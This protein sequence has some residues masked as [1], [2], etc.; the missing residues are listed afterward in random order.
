MYNLR[1][2]KFEVVDANGAAITSGLTATIQKSASSITVYDSARRASKANP[3]TPDGRGCFAFWSSYASVDIVLADAT[4]GA[5]TF[6]D[7]TP[8]DHRITLAK[9]SL[10]VENRMDA[11]EALASGK[12]IV[13]NASGVA[14]DVALSGDATISN[15]G[16]LTIAEGAVEDS[17]IEALADGEI[18]IGVDGTAANNAKVTV[19][20][21]ASLANDG[22]LTATH[23]TVWPM[24]V[25][26]TL[27]ID[28]DGAETNGGGV[29]G[30]S[31]V[32]LTEQA[33]ALCVVEDYD[34]G[35]S[36]F[37]QL[38]TSSSGAGFTADYQLFPDTEVE[39]DAAYFGGAV[40]FC[41][42]ALNISATVATYGADSITWEYWDGA[43]WS[44]LTIVQDQTDADDAD[45]D[46]P[47]QQDGAIH[48]IPP[49]DWAAVEVNSQSAYWIRARCNATVNITQIPL[50]DSKEHEIVTPTDGFICPHDGTISAIRLH[51]YAATLHTAA[52]IKF[53]LVNFTTGAHSG[54]LTFAQDIATDYWSSLSLAV[55]A[56]DVLGVLITAEDGTNEAV[57]VQLELDVTLS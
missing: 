31:G 34:G 5:Y 44:A 50:T 51:D 36:D 14:A 9:Q 23:R 57:N 48:F 46:R 41:E 27:G 29:H 42:L 3:I 17:M 2:Y 49:S 10:T 43:A 37:Q 47:F 35:G 16:A 53:C 15:T 21:D 20:G 24:A 39:N 1:Q 25:M 38:A 56:D 22:T 7:L 12:I 30:G 8:A 32:T 26:G 18:L 52:D 11:V 45:G 33:A 54:E 4:G 55:N 13:S 6:S 19:S 28:N 40:P